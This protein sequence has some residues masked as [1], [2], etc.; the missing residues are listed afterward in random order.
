MPFVEC[1]SFH[2]DSVNVHLIPF[3]MPILVLCIVKFIACNIKGDNNAA[4]PCACLLGVGIGHVHVLFVA[5]SFFLS[6]CLSLSLVPWYP[7]PFS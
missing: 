2:S 3:L 4:L 7:I 5:F 6:I 1:V